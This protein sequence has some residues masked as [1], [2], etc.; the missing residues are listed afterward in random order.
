M[1][2]SFDIGLSEGVLGSL[3]VYGKGAPLRIIGASSTR[4]RETFWWVDAKSPLLSMRKDDGQSITYS[5]SGASSHITVLRF[6]SE[7]GLKANPVATGD[8][9]GNIT[10]V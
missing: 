5:T 1:S 7:Y 2:G 9:P 6:I 3:V 4:S 8:V 10:L